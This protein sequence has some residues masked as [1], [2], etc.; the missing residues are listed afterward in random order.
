MNNIIMHQQDKVYIAG[1]KGMV[2][3]AIMRKLTREGFT[4]LVFRNSSDLD[5]RNQAAVQTFFEKERPDHVIL[6]AAKVGGILANNIYRAEFL[7]DNIMIQ[8]NVIHQ[9][10]VQGVKKLLFLGSSCIYPK[11]APQPLKEEYLLTG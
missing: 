9:S 5:L 1:Y 6:A 11:M 2:G 10:Y 4:N 3:S 7:Y 8:N